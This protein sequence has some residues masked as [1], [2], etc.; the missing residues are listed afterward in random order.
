MH[1]GA[2][3]FVDEGVARLEHGQGRV[4]DGEHRHGVP[5][6]GTVGPRQPE[7]PA[8]HIACGGHIAGNQGDV[9]KAG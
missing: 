9:G 4:A 6:Q 5:A 8:Q 3:R 7:H 1:A 2:V